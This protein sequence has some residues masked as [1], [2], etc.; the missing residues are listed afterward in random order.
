[1][2]YH[3]KMFQILK[4]INFCVGMR[5]LV[6]ARP[7]NEEDLGVP[8][9]RGSGVHVAHPFHHLSPYEGLPPPIISIKQSI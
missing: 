4:L 2:K 7:S 9:K 6:C 3:I 1:M 5:F 8:K